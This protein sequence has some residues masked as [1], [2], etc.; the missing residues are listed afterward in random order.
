MKYCFLRQIAKFGIFQVISCAPCGF[1]VRLKDCEKL[2]ES[3]KKK[4]K[5]EFFFLGN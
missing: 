4:K 5:S 2:K 1:A 3:V